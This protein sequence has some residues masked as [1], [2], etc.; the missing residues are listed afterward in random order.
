MA[1]ITASTDIG[2]IR[3]QVTQAPREPL[4]PSVV[5]QV[6]GA[7]SNVLGVVGDKLADT[8]QKIRTRD[9]TVDR[10][11]L[12]RSFKTLIGTE[13]RR[14]AT[15]EDLSQTQTGINFSTFINDA[16]DQLL[17]E[18]VGSEDSRATLSISLDDLSVQ[19]TD[20]LAI[21]S[22][23]ASRDLVEDSIRQEI[24]DIAI[25]VQ[26]NPENVLDS[27][28][29]VNEIIDD[30]G[31]A[32]SQNEMRDRREAGQQL[33]LSTAVTSMLDNGNIEGAKNLLETEGISEIVGSGQVL[34]FA[35]RI[36]KIEREINKG[37]R[38]G[39][40]AI[41]KMQ[42][43]LGPDVE[44]TPAM[45]LSAAG[46]SDAGLT[47]TQ[48]IEQINDALIASGQPTM[49]PQQTQKALGIADTESGGF[50]R[51]IVGRATQTVTD[52][53]QGFA[54]GTLNEEEDRQFRA[55]INVLQQPISFIDPDSGLVQTRVPKLAPFVLEALRKGGFEVTPQQ[56]MQPQLIVPEEA[57]LEGEFAEDEVTAEQDQLEGLPTIFEL[58][59]TITGPGAIVTEFVGGLPVFGGAVDAAAVTQGRERVKLLQRNLVKALQNNPRLQASERVAI[60]EEIDITGDFFDN[61]TAFRNRAKGIDD[62]LKIRVDN[63]IDILQSPKSGKVERISAMR[64]LN[65][66]ENFRIQLGAPPTMATPEDAAKLPPGTAFFTPDLELRVVPGGG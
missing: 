33:V 25:S 65:D 1:R 35:T 38:E 17:T 42:T 15:E 64:V 22:V 43:I 32:L 14:I 11:R 24:S 10:A 13:A 66:L 20:S 7:A 12:K 57:P 39:Q 41:A 55:S 36:N 61:P 4:I 5:E 34:K 52:L 29:A 27:L 54:N 49:T 23:T 9:D 26:Q 47:E 30:M 62:A 19:A 58:A 51:G 28:S 48:K 2:A 3:E 6:A 18:H 8:E 37:V 53:S 21:E 46:L 56:V 60:E 40:Q 31:P 59:D 16:R 50:G 45:R 63:M 44:I